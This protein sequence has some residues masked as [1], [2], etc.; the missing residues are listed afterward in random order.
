LRLASFVVKRLV[1][2]T[3]T[4][5][6]LSL[7][8]FYTASFFPAEQRA[9]LFV[10][11]QSYHHPGYDPWSRLPQIA[12]K[13]HLYDAFYVQY[14]N[15]LGVLFTER[16]LGYSYYYGGGI[17]EAILNSFPP[18][19][20]LVMYSAPIIILGG[21]KLGVYSAKREHEKRKRDDPADIIIRLATTLAY[22]MPIFF[23]GLLMISVFFL[24]LHWFA[25]GR[26]GRDAQMFISSRTWRSYTGLYTIDGIL[27]GQ[28]WIFIDALKHLVLPVATLTISMIPII[29]KVTRSSMLIE[30]S[31]PYVTMIRAKGLREVE[32]LSRVKR[33]AMISILTVTSII[34]ANMLTGIVVTENIFSLGGVGSLAVGAA[35]NYDFTLLVG[36]SIFFCLIFVT[37]NLI[38]DVAYTYIDP[39]VK[40]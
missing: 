21:I 18:T 35:K 15:W 3:L 39:R 37:V 4:L 23:T 10:S 17:V 33:N 34:F 11:P 24:N 2:T 32:V 6:V 8:I 16:T 14:L 13:Y 20:E 26:I 29:V 38:V 1:L 5:L 40:L 27:N 7:T 9:L 25:P 12:A 36:L 30:F 31:Q 19:L 22:S 28:F